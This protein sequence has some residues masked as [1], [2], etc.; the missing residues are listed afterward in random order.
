MNRQEHY[1]QR[2]KALR[3]TWHDSVTLYRQIIEQLATNQTRLLDVG[4]GHGDVLRHAYHD[5]ALAV[6]L[7]PDAAALHN[8]TVLQ[9]CICGVGEQLP[10]ADQSFDLIT[11]AWVLEHVSDPLAVLG[12]FWRV[13]RPHGKIVF[14]TPNTWNYNVWMIRAI[15]NRWHSF[16]TQ[17]LY[18]RQEHDT[19]PVQYRL[20]SVRQIERLAG[21][22][23]FRRSRML[24]NG[25][26]SYI[27]FNEPLFR[28]ACAIERVLDVPR[29]H[30]ARVHM[31]GVYEKI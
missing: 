18:N 8:N 28:L 6:G 14:L 29:L 11:S 13:L 22:S 26:P 5:S 17:R 15:P 4:C 24:L 1:R 25:D 23:G 9:H 27:S 19:Y 3:P 20:N 12:E 2:Y 30:T 16:F 31:I 7:E 10:F 21:R